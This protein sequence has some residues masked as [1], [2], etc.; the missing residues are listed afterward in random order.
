MSTYSGTGKFL[1]SKSLKKYLSYAD[2]GLA[3][4]NTGPYGTYRVGNLNLIGGVS[5]SIP[6]GPMWYST[7]DT[8]LEARNPKMIARVNSTVLLAHN[9]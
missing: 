8:N 3:P 2:N 5:D 7:I 9:I 6:M 1:N 4:I